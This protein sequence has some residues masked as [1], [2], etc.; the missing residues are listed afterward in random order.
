MDDP[1]T[2]FVTRE[3]LEALRTLANFIDRH[4]FTAVRVD[5]AGTARFE[6]ASPDEDCMVLR[7]V[8][9][10]MIRLAMDWPSVFSK[11]RDV[12]VMPPSLYEEIAAVARKRGICADRLTQILLRS[13]DPEK[14]VQRLQEG[15]AEATPLFTCPECR[16]VFSGPGQRVVERGTLCWDCY[17]RNYHASAQ[18]KEEQ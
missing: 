14:A 4:H 8:Q 9:Q 10:D 3:L 12:V 15:R 6:V 5:G 16:G 7:A 11:R 13:R 1:Y 18:A 17:K 2:R